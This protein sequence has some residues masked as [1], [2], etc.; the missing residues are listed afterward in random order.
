MA[1]FDTRK[2][3]LVSECAVCC[4]Q[5]RGDANILTYCDS[6]CE[7]K[8]SENKS[9]FGTCLKKQTRDHPHEVRRKGID[10]TWGFNQYLLFVVCTS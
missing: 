8:K 9:L 6:S 3:G 10:E 5:F 1:C 4:S 7:N 2:L